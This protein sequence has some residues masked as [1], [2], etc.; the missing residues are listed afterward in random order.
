[1]V[2]DALQSLVPATPP[3]LVLEINYQG[4][5]GRGPKGRTTKDKVQKVG[6]YMNFAIWA[7]CGRG[8]RV[9]F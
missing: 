6:I 8:T 3:V 9:D 1:M 4:Y 2:L 7:V 5:H